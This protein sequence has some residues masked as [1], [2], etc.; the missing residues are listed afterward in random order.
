MIK[1]MTAEEKKNY[2][3]QAYL[4][5]REKQLAEQKLYYQTHREEILK[6]QNLRYRKKCGL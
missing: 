2:R 4:K 6:K 5:R 1:T 3:H